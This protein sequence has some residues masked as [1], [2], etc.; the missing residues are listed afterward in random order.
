MFLHF[1]YLESGYSSNCL[2]E[3][4]YISTT[5]FIFFFFLIKIR[6]TCQKGWTCQILSF[7]QAGL[8]EEDC[9]AVWQETQCNAFNWHASVVWRLSLDVGAPL[10]EGWG[11]PEVFP[12]TNWFDDWNVATSG[13]HN[14]DRAGK[15]DGVNRASAQADILGRGCGVIQLEPTSGPER[16]WLVREDL[17]SML[18]Y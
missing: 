8:P 13:S 1:P 15:A 2:I 14:Q 9:I 5:S 11:A 16:W 7:S 10:R 4:T 3:K 17:S 6:M 18:L 12:T